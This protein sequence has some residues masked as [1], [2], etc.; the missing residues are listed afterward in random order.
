MLLVQ[1][2][3][4][5]L[6]EISS[7]SLYTFRELLQVPITPILFAGC[8]FFIFRFSNFADSC[9][10]IDWILPVLFPLSQLA[11]KT[12]K[13]IRNVNNTLVNNLRWRILV[14]DTFYLTLELVQCQVSTEHGLYI[15]FVDS[16][17]PI[18]NTITSGSPLQRFV[19]P[20]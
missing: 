9:A 5:A 10:S 2:Y 12:K 19:V 1:C 3:L 13:C 16:K 18:R 6:D 17:T 8:F 20:Y 14:I 7:C 15:V 4:V 11:Q